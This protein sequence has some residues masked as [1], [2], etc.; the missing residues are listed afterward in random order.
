MRD[1]DDTGYLKL[2][3]TWGHPDSGIRMEMYARGNMMNLILC[4]ISPEHRIQ[5]FLE[6]WVSREEELED[7]CS[8][9][10]VKHF[11]HKLVK[12]GVV[13]HLGALLNRKLVRT[14]GNCREDI[15]VWEDGGSKERYHDIYSTDLTYQ[16]FWSSPLNAL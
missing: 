5:G 10:W 7:L 14:L 4:K 9:C 3:G 16:C 12:S 1:K 15:A 11:K 13:V 8:L 6:I 2:P